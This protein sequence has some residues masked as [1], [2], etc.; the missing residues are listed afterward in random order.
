MC[1]FFHLSLYEPCTLYVR[2]SKCVDCGTSLEDTT[3]SA[4][5]RGHNEYGNAVYDLFELQSSYYKCPKCKKVVTTY[6]EFC[7]GFH[8]FVESMSQGK[9]NDSQK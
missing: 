1:Q 6:R 3:V 7:D 4:I 2:N 5:Y 9:T 8:F